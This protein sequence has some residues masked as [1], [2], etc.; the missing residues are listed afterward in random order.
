MT[1]VLPG[2]QSAFVDLGLEPALLELLSV[3]IFTLGEAGRER[4]A[5]SLAA[6]AKLLAPGD[7]DYEGRTQSPLVS[8]LVAGGIW[9]ILHRHAVQ[10]RGGELRERTGALSY[11]ALAPFIGREAAARTR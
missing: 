6:F 8:E 10:G 9:E 3:R 5:Q 4:D 11:L 2:M 1:R 7:R